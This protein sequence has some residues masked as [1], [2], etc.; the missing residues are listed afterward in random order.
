MCYKLLFIVIKNRLTNTTCEKKFILLYSK[1]KI[2]LHQIVSLRVPET[3]PTVFWES[4]TLEHRERRSESGNAGKAET[5][6]SVFNY[7]L[8]LFKGK[9][10]IQF[11]DK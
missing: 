9:V 4:P 6:C 7:V 11:K 3:V 10:E 2:Y 8:V 5:Q 1:L